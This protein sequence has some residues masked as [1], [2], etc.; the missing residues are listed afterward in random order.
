MMSMVTY[1]HIQTLEHPSFLPTMVPLNSGVQG[2]WRYSNHNGLFQYRRPPWPEATA[3]CLVVNAM[4]QTVM[5]EAKYNYII[6]PHTL[7][8][9]V[10]DG[11]Q[12]QL[13]HHPTRTGTNGVWRKPNTITSSSHTRSGYPWTRVGMMIYR[14]SAQSWSSVW[15][16]VGWTKESSVSNWIYLVAIIIYPLNKYKNRGFFGL[17][18]YILYIIL[19]LLI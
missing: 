12:I 2:K 10:H 16:A 18:I 1:V 13:H 9:T 15:G 7:G 11:S 17:Y 5:T 6:F 14:I 4:G 8:Q 3:E 19:V